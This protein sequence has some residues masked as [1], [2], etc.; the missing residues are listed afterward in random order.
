MDGMNRQTV[1]IWYGEYGFTVGC[2][3][4]SFF[5]YILELKE[6]I[7]EMKKFRCKEG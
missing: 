3:A 1:A 6:D 7:E 2:E 4:G 5:I